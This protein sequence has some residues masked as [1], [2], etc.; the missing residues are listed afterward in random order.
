Y[1][2]GGNQLPVATVNGTE[3]S[4]Y[5]YQNALARQRQAL[6]SQ[7]GSGFDPALLESLGIRDQVINGLI[8]NQVLSQYM[9]KRNFRVS[10]T[11][12]SRAIQQTPAFQSNGRFDPD[13]YRQAIA[14]AGYTTQGYEA[15]ERQANVNRQLRLALQ[16]TSFVTQNELDS[17]LAFQ[18]QT[19]QADYVVISADRFSNEVEVTDDQ[20]RIE[21]DNNPDGYQSPAR[22]KVDYLELSVEEL[23]KGVE[24][25]DAE[26]EQMW[27]QVSGRFKT[28]ESR[29]ASHILFSVKRSASDEDKADIR[30]TAEDVLLRAQDGEDFAALAGEYSE[31]P[32][33][34]A[35]GGDLGVVAIGQM[36]KPFEDAVFSMQ[37]DEIRGLVESRFGFHIIKLT[38]LIQEQQQLLEDVRDEIVDEVRSVQAENLFAELGEAFQ[39]LV[40]EEEDSLQ[41]T[42]DELGLELQTSE[43]FTENSGDGIA[44]EGQVRR[45][46]FSQDVLEA[47]LNSETIEIGFDRM[48]ALRKNNYESVARL[49]FSDVE[50]EI[51]SDLERQASVDK[52]M[53]LGESLIAGL[54]QGQSLE[55]LGHTDLVFEALPEKRVEISGNLRGL[56]DAVFA[57]QNLEAGQTQYGGVPL[58][59]GDF[60]LYLL[61]DIEF[62]SPSSVDSNVR[63]R[64]E[65]QLS[66]R[67]GNMTYDSF[68][69]L[70]R[71][72]ADVNIDEELLSSDEIVQGY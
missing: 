26:I 58:A 62:A 52:V 67:E 13:A 66:E 27:A 71:E 7:L 17:L 1:L 64:V 53:E 63:T 4:A 35:N 30:A 9:E 60:A 32:G 21:Y 18:E 59:N 16:D 31:D 25:S 69:G 12:L 51:R 34:A 42:A 61:K 39:N 68:A 47:D 55:S 40:Y 33:S 22:I 36:V 46:A 6:V 15:A 48:I 14:R 37:Q 54:Q 29:R 11:Q 50:A 43:W 24:P 57:A 44:S 2:E 23:A 65:T 38:E 5:D 70:L 72:L 3:I 10:D 56:G 20:V 8:G 19:R 45:A 49:E 41:A 28:A